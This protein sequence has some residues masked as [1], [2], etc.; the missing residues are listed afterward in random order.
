[1]VNAPGA[2]AIAGGTGL[3][4]DNARDGQSGVFG[5]RQHVRTT[6]LTHTRAFAQRG[7]LPVDRS[8]LQNLAAG[9]VDT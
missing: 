8:C 3:A 6:G 4:P 2:R 1:M 9:L 7:E 5:E